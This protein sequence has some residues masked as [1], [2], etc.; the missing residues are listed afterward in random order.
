MHVIVG[1]GI[2]AI[3]LI[4]DTMGRERGDAGAG[5]RQSACAFSVG[6]QV[7]DLK[8]FLS[9]SVSSHR[10]RSHVADLRY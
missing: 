3:E 2:K 1:R 4:S 8:R 10:R 7:Q 6:E 5:N 9:L